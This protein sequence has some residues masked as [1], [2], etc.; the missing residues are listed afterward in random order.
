[1][2]L[3]ETTTDASDATRSACFAAL[4][5]IGRVRSENQ[6]ACGTFRDAAGR[7]LFVVA[8]G[9][10]GHRG[11]S[12]A[13]RL[14]VETLGRCF[15]Q[16]SGAL[17]ECLERA[18]D[19]ANRAVLAQSQRDAALAGMGTTVVAFAL[20]GTRGFAAWVGD[21]RAYRLRGAELAPLTEDHSLVAA[22]VRQRVLTAEQ[23]ALHPRRNELLHCIGLD[24]HVPAAL[25]EVEL[26]PGDRV[27]LCSDGLWGSVP[28]PEIAQLAA[29]EPL[30]AA[31]AA[32][33]AR[34]NAGG[35]PDNITVQLA[36]IPAD[37]PPSAPPPVLRMGAHSR[38]IVAALV[39]GLALGLAWLAAS[40]LLGRAG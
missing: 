4:S 17:A 26:R 18:I 13:S 12:T 40:F 5:D 2:Q 16:S 28:E 31:V 10:G 29:R 35:G 15:E 24:E 32:L 14:C 38:H 23:A 19:E 22:W 27:L 1:V 33:V 36:R 39:L 34:A 6:D 11:G 7:Q 25:R 20:E 3:D 21:S 8:D 37:E 30:E 9:M